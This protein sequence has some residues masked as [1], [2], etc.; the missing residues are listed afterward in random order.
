MKSIT[1]FARSLEQRFANEE[2][3]R[4]I[5]IDGDEPGKECVF[6]YAKYSPGAAMLKLIQ[7]YN[8]FPVRVRVIGYI[9]PA[10]C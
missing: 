7:A 3:Y 2:W 9:K 5:G 10:S 4:F 8:D 1:E 6:V